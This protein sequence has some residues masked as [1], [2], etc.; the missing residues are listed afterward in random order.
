MCLNLF[1]VCILLQGLVNVVDR[2]WQVQCLWLEVCGVGVFLVVVLFIVF[3]RMC[4]SFRVFQFLVFSMLQVMW[5]LLWL[6]VYS[7]FSVVWVLM[8]LLWFCVLIR[9][10]QFLCMLVWYMVVQCF[11]VCCYWLDSVRWLLRM[12]QF[13]SLFCVQQVLVL[14]LVSVCG[15]FCGSGS[16]VQCF[17]GLQVFVFLLVGMNIWKCVYV[18]RFSS[19]FLGNGCS[20]KLLFLLWWM[21]ML[22]FLI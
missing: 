8:L 7:C 1:M 6:V 15:Q 18:F 22:L 19:W 21:W 10:L 9:F 13:C 2:F 16:I 17:G 12:L 3:C 4:F 11:V 5:C 20:M 14:L